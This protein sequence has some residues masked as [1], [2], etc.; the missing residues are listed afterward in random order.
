MGVANLLRN[1]DWCAYPP[2]QVCAFTEEVRAADNGPGGVGLAVRRSRPG[3]TALVYFSGHGV[4]APEHYLLP[5]GHRMNDLPGR[6]IT[7]REFTE[8]L[9]AIRAKK[10]IVLLDCCFAGGQAEAKG[11][12]MDEVAGTAWDD[13]NA[14]RQ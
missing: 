1:P 7:G 10:L 8:K 2:D 5:H 12:R 3:A 11:G 6:A 13:R 14:E 9:C 4:E